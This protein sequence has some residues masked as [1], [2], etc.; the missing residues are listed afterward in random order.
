MSGMLVSW[1]RVGRACAQAFQPD[2]FVRL[3]SLTY[4]SAHPT[5]KK[6]AAPL[7]LLGWGGPQGTSAN[8]GDDWPIASVVQS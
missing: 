8:V 7:R 2:K 4:S 1:S 3:E 6:Q 5:L